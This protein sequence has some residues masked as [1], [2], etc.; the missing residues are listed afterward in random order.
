MLPILNSKRKGGEGGKREEVPR[1][2]EK[3]GRGGVATPPP[4]PVNSNQLIVRGGLVI[5]RGVGHC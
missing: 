2:G 4:Y 5:V 3:G 1:R